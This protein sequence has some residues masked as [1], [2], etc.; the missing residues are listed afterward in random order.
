MMETSSQRKIHAEI[1]PPDSTPVRPGR[2]SS[3]GSIAHRVNESRR[4]MRPVTAAIHAPA[5]ADIGSSSE[6]GPWVIVSRAEG[7]SGS[8]I[9]GAEHTGKSEVI[10]WLHSHPPS[11]SRL[12]ALPSVTGEFSRPA[13]AASRPSLEREELRASHSWRASR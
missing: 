2:S 10:E 6:I 8:G 12:V 13:S 7:T 11:R 5:A 3:F 9:S 4:E 1:S